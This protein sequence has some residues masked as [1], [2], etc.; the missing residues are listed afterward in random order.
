MSKDKLNKLSLK[1]YKLEWDVENILW[2]VMDNKDKKEN[3]L[4]M[5]TLSELN[6]ILD[7]ANDNAD[8]L[9]G[10]GFLSAKN[11][12]IMGADINSFAHLTDEKLIGELLDNAHSVF[13]KLDNLKIPTACGIN[14][15]CLGGGLETALAFKYRVVLNDTANKNKSSIGFP[16]V[17]LGI[18]P[19]FGGTFRSVSQLGTIN[20]LTMMLTSKNLKPSLAR[21]FGI[22][23]KLVDTRSK[24]RWDIR[25]KLLKAKGVIKPTTAGFV[26]SLPNN[27]LLRPFVY[28]KLKKELNKKVNKNHYP[29][30]YRLLDI[31]KKSGSNYSKMQDLEKSNFAEMMISPT[32]RNLQRI[33]HISNAMKG[34][35]KSAKKK[36]IRN[37][38]I[39]GAGTMG[40][41]IAIHCAG[42]GYRVTIQDLS[43]DMLNKAQQSAKK[44]F[45]KRLKKPQL[46]GSAMTRF[47]L[48]KD[49]NGLASADVV[50]EAIVENLEIKQNLF[51]DVESKVAKDTI[52]ATNT[53]AIPLEKIADGMVNKTRLIGL[54]FFN[55]AHTLPLVE[56]VKSDFVDEDCLNLGAKFVKDIG[57]FP[58]IVKSSPGFLVNRVL[59]PYIMKALQLEN[60]GTYNKETIDKACREFGMPMG[61]VELADTVGLDIMANVAS[62]L[63]LPMPKGSKIDNLITAGNLGRKTGSGYYEWQKGRPVKTGSVDNSKDLMEIAHEIISPLWLE[64][65]LCLDEKIVWV[66]NE[67]QSS[68]LID[69]GIIFGTGFA[70][71]L[72]GAL[73][74]MK[75]LKG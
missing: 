34:L 55:P 47:V 6:D 21:V 73:N 35:A 48:D 8:N 74:Y 63:K 19:G 66:D 57:K 64:A 20:A 16:E 68:D 70:P 58:L 60:D 39:I 49:G 38:H 41:D 5:E 27:F 25:K 26:K 13:D 1:N 15:F 3:T 65:K 14:G 22:A 11:N 36:T 33:Y 10:L 75:T 40:A 71:H 59:S 51:K 31:W 44:F 2:V 67:Q 52:L 56:V 18:Y 54:H 29:A 62:E 42:K 7:F 32:A 46:V 53:S 37:I 12:F 17:K 28:N 50:I 9:I 45:K 23:H 61:P 69:G 43:E 4:D 72:G 24:L 30:P